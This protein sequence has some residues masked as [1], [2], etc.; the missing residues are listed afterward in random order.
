MILNHDQRWY[1]MRSG[2]C[3]KHVVSCMSQNRCIN[4]AKRWEETYALLKTLWLSQ[5]RY[6]RLKQLSGVGVQYHKKFTKRR[7]LS[8]SVCRRV[9]TCYE[10][11][12]TLLIFWRHI[13]W[14]CLFALLNILIPKDTECPSILSVW[15]IPPS[16]RC[17]GY[18]NNNSH[19]LGQVL[20]KIDG[21]ALPTLQHH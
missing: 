3:N 21:L 15:M 6:G 17:D 14:V 4:A 2:N 5:Q 18:N 12:W 11:R 1:I 10:T 16:I 9:A 19:N 13:N 20:N 8:G 7:Q